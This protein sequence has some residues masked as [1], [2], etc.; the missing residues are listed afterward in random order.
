[1]SNIIL[2]ILNKKNYCKIFV[3]SIEEI[4][5]NYSYKEFKEAFNYCL[6]SR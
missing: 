5:V 4:I 2:D 6:L 1:M 3:D